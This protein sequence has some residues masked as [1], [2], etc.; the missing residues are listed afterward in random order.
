MHI[1]HTMQI[2]RTFKQ[3]TQT[4]YEHALA[5]TSFGRLIVQLKLTIITQ[6]NYKVNRS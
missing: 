4:S 6:V 3:K 5:N 2:T 1:T